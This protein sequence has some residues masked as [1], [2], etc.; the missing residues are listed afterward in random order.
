[1]ETGKFKIGV[2]QEIQVQ[3]SPLFVGY[4][5]G[6]SIE[7]PKIPLVGLGQRIVEPLWMVDSTPSEELIKCSS[8]EEKNIHP[9]EIR[10]ILHDLR[11]FSIVVPVP[12]DRYGHRPVAFVLV[13]L[14]E[15]LQE[16]IQ[17]ALQTHL[18]KFKHP[19]AIFLLLSVDTYK[20]SRRTL[21]TIACNLIK[22]P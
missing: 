13:D 22:S 7:D 9:E 3:G 14:S 17:L 21:K 16:Q 12:H 8:P 10:A 2:N 18:P 11:I 4:W 15:D 6:D 20:P 5:N 19:D 1:M